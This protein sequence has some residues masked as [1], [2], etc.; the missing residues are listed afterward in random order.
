[1][2][3]ESGTP[4]KKITIEKISRVY[5]IITAVQYTTRIGQAR[6]YMY[7]LCTHA[8]THTPAYS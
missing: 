8:R 1:M 4:K 2:M 3:N 6:T 5:D 7:I